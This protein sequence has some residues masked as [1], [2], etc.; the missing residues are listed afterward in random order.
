MLFQ[1]PVEG[2]FKER[3][4]RF[5]ATAILDGKTVECFFPNPGRLEELRG[6]GAPT[7]L[8]PKSSENRKTSY[9][10][11]AIKFS[12]SWVSIDSR[13][14]NTVIKESLERHELEPFREYNKIIPE[15][16]YKRSRL[17]FLLKAPG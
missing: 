16:S 10:M 12:D 15:Y 1:G 14:P 6:K 9:D 11:V 7:L 3:V 13:V 4:N 17:D 5:L 2:V 8:V